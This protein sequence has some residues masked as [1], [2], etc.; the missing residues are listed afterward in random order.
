MT[1]ADDASRTRIDR[2]RSQGLGREGALSPENQ[3]GYRGTGAGPTLPAPDGGVRPYSSAPDM[4]RPV[5]FSNGGGQD[6]ASQSQARDAF[7]A[8]R[9]SAADNRGPVDVRSYVG[10][11]Y[12]PDFAAN[13]PQIQPVAPESDAVKIARIAVEGRTPVAGVTPAVA[14]SVSTPAAP[15]SRV[16][17]PNQGLTTSIAPGFAGPRYATGSPASALPAGQRPN[18]NDARLAAVTAPANAAPATPAQA[19]AAQPAAGVFEL[20]YQ[21]PD[22]T[23][24]AETRDGRSQ[25]FRTQEEATQFSRGSVPVAPVAPVAPAAP[26]APAAPSPISA[27]APQVMPF[28]APG[29]PILPQS[30]A[31]AAPAPFVRPAGRVA[32]SGSGLAPIGRGIQPAQRASLAPVPAAPVISRAQ[33]ATAAAQ[34]AA[35]PSPI[36]AAPAPQVMTG[37]EADSPISAA[38]AEQSPISAAP[39][40]ARPALPQRIPVSTP[41]N[42]PR[43]I[44]RTPMLPPAISTPS[45]SSLRPNR[46]A[47]SIQMPDASVEPVDFPLLTAT[48]SRRPRARLV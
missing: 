2:E 46:D 38:P 16:P 42:N 30:A 32:A 36:S 3:I 9:Q 6:A 7:S 20:T 41:V 14:P 13:N 23:F 35:Q 48:G 47:G 27:A 8:F 17:N 44:Q 12:S 21:K 26:N 24:H 34:R 40:V 11:R 19:A 29:N 39:S 28:D 15:V 1:S 43:A 33:A 4:D 22:G 10:S 45:P 5:S 37:L 25:T 31:P 18:E